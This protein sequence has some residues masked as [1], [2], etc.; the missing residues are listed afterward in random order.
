MPECAP[1]YSES[2]KK[3]S[4]RKRMSRLLGVAA[5]AALIVACDPDDK[6]NPATTEN[7]SSSQGTDD[8]PP[9]GMT[10]G[11]TT[12]E[13]GETTGMEEAD[14]STDGSTSGE[15]DSDA[16]METTGAPDH[17]TGN[18]GAESTG[19]PE[20]IPPP[21]PVIETHGGNEK[22][23]IFEV[24]QKEFLFEGSADA[25][26]TQK[27]FIQVDGFNPD[28]YIDDPEDPNYLDPE[29]PNFEWKQHWKEVVFV[30]GK[31]QITL[32]V[33]PIDGE[34]HEYAVA[35]GMGEEKPVMGDEDSM[36]IETI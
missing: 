19:G 4:Y 18:G 9:G 21:A 2:P 28:I 36:L 11:E 17:T 22:W 14:A 23:T 6:T 30:D 12:G 26:R 5:S 13:P 7:T 32:P 33:P 31:W 20:N 34:Y 10:P 1:D 27:V 24:N 35:G 25:S 15:V 29:D 8:M 3:P 16:G